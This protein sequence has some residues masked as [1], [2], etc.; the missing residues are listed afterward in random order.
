ML[1]ETAQAASVAGIEALNPMTSPAPVCVLIATLATSE[2]AP[3]LLRALGSLRAQG[4]VV[5][6]AIVVVN[7]AVADAALL[8]ELER[9][10]GE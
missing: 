8:R 1:T 9:L 4:P 3:Y 6:R 2:R 5:T 7:G 10:P